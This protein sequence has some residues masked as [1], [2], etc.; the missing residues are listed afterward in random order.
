METGKK[1][2]IG[3][4]SDGKIGVRTRNNEDAHQIWESAM[5]KFE[6]YYLE[7]VGD[8]FDG[9]QHQYP[10][11]TWFR[12]I[13]NR[14]P[15][16]I[17]YLIDVASD[18]IES[19]AINN[20]RTAMTNPKD[21]SIVPSVAIAMGFPQNDEVAQY[22]KKKYKANRVYNYFEQDY[23]YLEMEEVE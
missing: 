10:S 14:N 18:D 11:E 22:S 5:Q 9:S 3:G 7:T 17:I 21:S 1:G 8:Y 15:L 16:V 4:P 23:N 6:N 20:Y 12:F 19:K 13:K 2:R